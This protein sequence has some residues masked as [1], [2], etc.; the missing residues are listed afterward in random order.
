MEVVIN[1]Q[2]Q[3]T[4]CA[5]KPIRPSIIKKGTVVGVNPFVPSFP[6][7]GNED[8]ASQFKSTQSHQ[9]EARLSSRPPSV[10]GFQTHI[11]KQTSLE[12]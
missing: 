8:Q 9:H 2:S 4:I 10:A 11:K 5:P 3:P 12:K 7:N 6:C 1:R